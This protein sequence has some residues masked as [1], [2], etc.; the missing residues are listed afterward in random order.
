ME[1][2]EGEKEVRRIEGMELEKALL[3]DIGRGFLRKIV[4]I[5]EAKSSGVKTISRN[6][7]V[8][9]SLNK[10]RI[11]DKIGRKLTF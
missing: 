2:E 9:M 4:R 6:N 3:E 8:I 1:L 10:Q 11:Q 7:R 5:I